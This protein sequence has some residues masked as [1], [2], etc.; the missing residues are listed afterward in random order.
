MSKK[1]I[2]VY[3]QGQA[4]VIRLPKMVV[5]QLNVEPGTMFKVYVEDNRVVLEK[6][7]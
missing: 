5:E 7:E 4:L 2:R 3:K 6:I 1:V